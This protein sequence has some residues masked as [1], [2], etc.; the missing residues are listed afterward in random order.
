MLTKLERALNRLID[1]FATISGVFLVCLVSINTYAV[2]KR[3]LFNNPLEWS[4]SVSNM[5]MVACVFFGATHTLQKE[6]HVSVDIVI[7]RLDSKTRD[8]LTLI[9]YII[10]LIFMSVLAWHS[11]FLAWNHLYTS[12]DSID[13]LP[14]FP[15]YIIIPIGSSIL[16]FHLIV[17]IIKQILVYRET[18]GAEN[19]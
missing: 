19:R 11:W 1:F 16:C 9:K 3:Y 13:K 8:M 14:L 2:I 6:G 12:T 18:N 15:T 4:I 7:D 10:I 5:L 17:K